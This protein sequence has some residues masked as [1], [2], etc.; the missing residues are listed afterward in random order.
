MRPLVHIMILAA[1]AICLSCSSDQRNGGIPMP[2]DS[3]SADI[4]TLQHARIFFGHRSVG[5]NILNGVSLIYLSQSSRT[6]ET[7]AAGAPAFRLLRDT[8]HYPEW[9]FADA[10]IGEN[11]RPETKCADF[12]R[13]LGRFTDHPP[14]FAM[15]KF[16]FI[17]FGYAMDAQEIFQLYAST[18]DSL[19]RTY[20]SITF[21]HCTAPL[22]ARNTSIKEFIKRLI[23]RGERFEADNRARTT[24][25]RLMRE[26]YAGEPIF[27]LAAVESTRPDGTHETFGA[28]DARFDAMVPEYTDDGGHLNET[29]QRRAAREFIRTL[30]AAI[31]AERS[32]S[33][34]AHSSP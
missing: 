7:S 23:G 20:P 19:K 26:R 29:A 21:V 18:I 17:D 27:D 4:A 13:L 9:Y 32:M 12:V 8:T 1:A 16:C 15:M 11:T 28:G 5:N 3:L 24:F 14:E 25:N 34:L 22:T 30:A 6:G 31:R 10:L 2:D 33:A